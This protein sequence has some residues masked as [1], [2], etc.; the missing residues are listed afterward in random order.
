MSMSFQDPLNDEAF[1]KIVKEFGEP[2]AVDGERKTL[3]FDNIKEIN[4]LVM[5]EIA[6]TA[7]QPTTVELHGEGEIKTMS[8]GS[9]YQV[10]SRGW[11]KLPD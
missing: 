10:T 1:A 8:D 11:V 5:K 2:V 7:K 6:N 4:Q 3:L 9:R